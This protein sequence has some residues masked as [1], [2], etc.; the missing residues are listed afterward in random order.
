MTKTYHNPSAQA[1][2]YVQHA[3][4]SKDPYASSEVQTTAIL[5][6]RIADLEK[7]LENKSIIDALTQAETAI[8]KAL[9][10]FQKEVK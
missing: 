1:Q 9:V 5:E 10:H 7:Q 4:F 3:G 8:A 6:R 2:T